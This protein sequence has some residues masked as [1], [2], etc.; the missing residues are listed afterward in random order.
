MS[1][2]FQ[3]YCIPHGLLSVALISNTSWK[4]NR[5]TKQAHSVIP[6]QEPMTMVW[7]WNISWG[8]FGTRIVWDPFWPTEI[9]YP[10]PWVLVLIPHIW[11]DSGE[12]SHPMN[13]CSDIQ[14]FFVDIET[15]VVWT[16]SHYF[17]CQMI[18]QTIEHMRIPF[19]LPP[20]S[21]LLFILSWWMFCHGKCIIYM[22]WRNYWLTLLAPHIVDL[23]E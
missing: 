11:M 12:N 7:N 14:R 5:V 21:W 20:M 10:I 9:F 13:K 16:F 8:S 3:A 6:Q 4:L 1:S 15:Y 2:S 23:P 18:Q 19:A 22:T 17:Q